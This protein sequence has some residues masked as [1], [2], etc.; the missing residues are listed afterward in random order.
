M[1][2]K[3]ELADEQLAIQDKKEEEVRESIIAEF[4][5]DEVDD[6][7]RIDKLVEKE[8]EHHKK[9]SSAIGQK[10]KHRAEAEEL[11]TKLNDKPPVEKKDPVSLDPEIISK[12]VEERLE[13]RDLDSLDYPD[14]LKK[15]IKRI[16]DITQVSIKQA[17]RDPYIVA[18]IKDHEKATEAEEASISR[19]NR[20]GN[21]KV[22]SFDNP[23][24][25]DMNTAEGRK[26]WDE[27]KAKQIKEGN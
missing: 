9:L 13:K 5:F 23:P 11:R 18:K 7:E 12:T 17:V 26:A 4:G 25:V 8:M 24:D 14:E 10:I 22:A 2:N 21:G 1:D 16:A 20:T 3:Q 6:I 19:T 27:W 15:E